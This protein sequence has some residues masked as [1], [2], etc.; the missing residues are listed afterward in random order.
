VLV[1]GGMATRYFESWW[2][3]AFPSRV[4]LPKERIANPDGT[5]TVLFWDA[6]A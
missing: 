2:R 1:D 6:F 4:A 3:S 5:G